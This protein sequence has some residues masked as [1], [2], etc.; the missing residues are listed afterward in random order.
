MAEPIHLLPQNATPFETAL[1]LTSTPILDVDM[2][3]IRRS[4]L[5]GQCDGRLL[6]WL[7]LRVS[8]DLWRW[9]WPEATKRAVISGS[10]RYHQTKGTVYALKRALAD[11]DF[12]TAVSEW[13]QYGG[14]PYYFRVTVTSQT[15][16]LTLDDY[17]MLRRVIATAWGPRTAQTITLYPQGTF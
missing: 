8:V 9:D 12:G 7:A 10:F 2:D 1:S 4:R 16:P 17:T 6:P 13:F 5:A 3:V 11:L 14:D 15:R